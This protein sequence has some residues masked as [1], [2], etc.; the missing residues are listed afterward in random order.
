MLMKLT[1]RALI[2]PLQ[3]FAKRLERT[4]EESENY[5]YRKKRKSDEHASLRMHQPNY[6]L[7]ITDYYAREFLSRDKRNLKI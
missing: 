3:I 2:W 4:S 6:S 1:R 5:L 7:A